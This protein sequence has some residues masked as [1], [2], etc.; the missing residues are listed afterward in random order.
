MSKISPEL[1]E[2][3]KPLIKILNTKHEWTWG[4][5]QTVADNEIKQLLISASV[6]ALN[7]Y[8]LPTKRLQRRCRLR[9]GDS[10]VDFFS[11]Y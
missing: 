1:A 5:S 8:K 3:S 2:K 4:E 10:E 6:L 7:D 11:L 9:F